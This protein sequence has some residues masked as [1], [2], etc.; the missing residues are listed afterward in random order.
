MAKPKKSGKP[1]ALE[2][3]E[4]DEPSLKDFIEQMHGDGALAQPQNGLPSLVWI[5]EQFRTKSAA[6]RFLVNQGHEVK[7]IAKHL[8]V[9]YQM[10]RNIAHNPLKRGPNE[11]W[12]KPLVLGIKPLVSKKE[13][14]EPRDA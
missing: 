8:G 9:R 6:I 1:K 5:K 2:D 10:V 7:V 12:T 11:D 4:G 3:P 13:D 14:D